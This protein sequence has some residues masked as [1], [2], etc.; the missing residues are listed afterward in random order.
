[1]PTALPVRPATAPDLLNSWPSVYGLTVLGTLTAD[2][3]GDGRDEVVCGVEDERV[4][5]LKPDGTQLWQRYFEAQRSQGG[6]EGH[7]RV[8]LAAD[9]DNDGSPEV[10]VGCANSMFYVLD[11][12]GNLKHSKGRAWDV[13][14]QHQASAIGAA[15]VTGD[16]QLEL[17][18]GYTYFGR[19]IVDFADTSRLRVSNLGGCISGCGTIASADVDG[20]GRPEAIFADKDGQIAACRKA[21]DRRGAAELLWTKMIGDDAIVTALA[22][23]FDGDTK[24]EV[25]VA[26]HSGFLALLNADGSVR[27]IRYSD[28]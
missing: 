1:M 8:V 15:D 11:K 24:P 19:R 20:D 3:D 16:G 5:V 23:D 28:N 27:W 17:L 22:G 26:S 13:L 10:A 7:V 6:R 9:F 12:E 14:V 25:L 21:R 18:A 4:H 2:L